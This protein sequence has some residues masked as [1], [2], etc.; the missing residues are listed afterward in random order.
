M[1][2]H[3]FQNSKLAGIKRVLSV[4]ERTLIF[5][6]WGI[7]SDSRWRKWSQ[8]ILVRPSPRVY[9]T[10][11]RIEHALWCGFVPQMRVL[12]FGWQRLSRRVVVQSETALR[13][14]QL[15]ATD[16]R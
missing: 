11:A 16:R 8:S 13:K 6:R 14:E 2:P 7:I 9:G 12:S 4:V 10:V 5:S 15:L 3:S 1:E